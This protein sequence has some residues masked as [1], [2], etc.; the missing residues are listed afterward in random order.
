MSVP[1]MAN[2]ITLTFS[3]FPI[4]LKESSCILGNHLHKQSLLIQLH[5]SI[6]TNLKS[7]GIFE[8]IRQYIETVFFNFLHLLFISGRRHVHLYRQFHF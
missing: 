2:L 6:A 7:R 8:R 4:F 5:K 3:R 1:E